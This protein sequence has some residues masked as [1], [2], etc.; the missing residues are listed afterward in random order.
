MENI[1]SGKILS[2]EYPAG[3]RL[4]SI[5]LL[6][7]KLGCSY[8]TLRNAIKNL[9][10]KGLL[11]TEQGSGTYVTDQGVVKS[12]QA[13]GAREIIYL[14]A[15]PAENAPEEYELEIYH[16]F[17]KL[18]RQ[19]GYLDRMIIPFEGLDAFDPEKS[20]IAGALVTHHCKTAD[21]LEK[22]GIPLVYCTSIPPE[23]S[24]AS[25]NPDFYSGSRLAVEY[26]TE[27]GHHKILFI[28]TAS[29]DSYSST[30]RCR[31]QGY[32]DEMRKNDLQELPPISWH[33]RY[34]RE[35][36]KKIVCSQ[37]R[38]DAIFAANDIMAT[39]IMSMLFELDIRVPEDISIIG[40]EDMRCSK[41]SI[42]KLSTVG[43]DKSILA[44]ETVGLLMDCMEKKTS[45]SIRKLIPMQL[46]K[47][48]SVRTRN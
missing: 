40:L 4:P 14:F 18:V 32:I 30:F 2:G 44:S 36:L 22:A 37:K 1:L 34:A 19:L 24:T 41:L 21:K 5:R 27:T 28:T 20:T 3:E 8:V 11:K 47:R 23:H 26:L 17:Q 33:H 13:Y 46:I 9:E 43:Y 45:A 35:E 38:P 12:I 16:E 6:S 7:D 42:P 25:V 31:H 48:E 29:E 39:E 15:D 10:K